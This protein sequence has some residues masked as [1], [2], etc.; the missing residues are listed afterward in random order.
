MRDWVA[1]CFPNPTDNA[2]AIGECQALLAVLDLTANQVNE[3][4]E[5]E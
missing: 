2:K 1:G 3:G 4:M 5:D